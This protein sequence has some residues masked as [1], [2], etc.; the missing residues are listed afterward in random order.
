[1][2]KQRKRKGNAT[3]RNEKDGQYLPIPYVMARSVAFRSLSGPALK[4]WVELRT[5]YNGHNNGLVSLSLR[6]AAHLLGMSQTTAQRALLELADKGFIKLRTRGSFP[7]RKAAEFILTDK[8][9]Q[10]HPPSRD[11][12]SWRPKNKSSVPR[13]A[14]KGVSGSSQYRDQEFA[15]HQSSRQSNLRV[16][17]GAA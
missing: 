1:M 10:G 7:G 3:G 17:N 14:A 9:Y 12:Q 4:V 15:V 13:R 16:I 6:E 5:R 8:A 11:W 2:P